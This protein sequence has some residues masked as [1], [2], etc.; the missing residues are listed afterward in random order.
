MALKIYI[1][2]WGLVMALEIYIVEWGLVMA[3]GHTIDEW[4]KLNGIDTF[5]EWRQLNGIEQWHGPMALRS[6]E[7]RCC[8]L[9]R[10]CR[11]VHF[12]R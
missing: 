8:L 9:I 10:N 3:L 11:A 12:A 2:Q 5:D 6:F 1:V 7:P 4:R